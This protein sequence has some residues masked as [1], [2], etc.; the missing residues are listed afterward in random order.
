MN[1]RNFLKGGLAALPATIAAV[2][3][4]EAGIEAIEAKDFYQVEPMPGHVDD[5]QLAEMFNEMHRR[6]E[7]ATGLTPDMVD[8]CSAGPQLKGSDPFPNIWH[9]KP[10]GEWYDRNWGPSIVNR[11]EHLEAQNKLNNLFRKRINDANR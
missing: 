7:E 1:R 3:I 11:P 2:K 6:M 10:L 8:G 4:S 9:E 5:N